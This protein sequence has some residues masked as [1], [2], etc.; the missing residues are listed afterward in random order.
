MRLHQSNVRYLYIEGKIMQSDLLDRV[1]ATIKIDP[2]DGIIHSCFAL[3]FCSDFVID[4]QIKL[5]SH[6]ASNHSVMRCKLDA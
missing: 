2:A 4:A 5:S 6:H 1:S 3:V